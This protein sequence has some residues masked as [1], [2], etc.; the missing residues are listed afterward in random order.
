VH[1]FTPAA[2]LVLAAMNGQRTVQQLWQLAQRHLGEQAPTQDELIALLGQLHGLDLLDADVPPDALELF[3]RGDKA[4]AQKRRRMWMNPMAMRIPLWDPGL[5]LDRHAAWWR[6]L[7]SPMAPR[8]GW[9]SCCR[10]WCCCRS[11]GPS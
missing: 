2:R 4:A 10:R 7:W 6:G 8:C 1:R 11:P 5:F 9:P 3:S